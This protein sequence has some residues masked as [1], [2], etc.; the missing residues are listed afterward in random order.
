M[1]KAALKTQ[2]KRRSCPCRDP[3]CS[4]LS[5]VGMGDHESGRSFGSLQQRGLPLAGPAKGGREFAHL[6]RLALCPQSLWQGGR[7]REGGREAKGNQKE[8][9]CSTELTHTAPGSSCK[10]FPRAGLPQR[11]QRCDGSGRGSLFHCRWE[12]LDTNSCPG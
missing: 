11:S 6:E 3:F 7:E 9:R 8:Q 10:V 2:G 1:L 5:A 4:H 12:R